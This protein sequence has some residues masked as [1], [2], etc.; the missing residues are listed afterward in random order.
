VNLD[1]REKIKRFII[2]IIVTTLA[3]LV[4]L[5]FIKI[6][7]VDNK[8]NYTSFKQNT[9][10]FISL[11]EVT[12][13]YGKYVIVE[14]KITKTYNSGKACFLNFDENYKRY[15]TAVIF[16]SSFPVF[17]PNPENYYLNKKV[18]IVGVIKE[19]QGSPEIILNTKDQI[20][21]IDDS[22]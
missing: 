14:G 19:Y 21:I 7:F 15:L 20:E 3:I 10:L 11:N 12:K 22:H 5:F 18:R 8:S 13:H 6:W 2:R 16:A 1:D 17:P 9:P 4:I